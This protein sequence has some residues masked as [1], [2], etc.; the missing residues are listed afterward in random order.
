MALNRKCNHHHHHQR[1]KVE[2]IATIY[3]ERTSMKKID[4]KPETHVG[5]LNEDF[6]K[7]DFYDIPSSYNRYNAAVLFATYLTFNNIG[8]AGTSRSNDLISPQ[9]FDDSIY[10]FIDNSNI[11]AGFNL[12]LETANQRNVKR[13]CL[14]ASKPL[15]KPLTQA[16]QAGYEC[17]VLQQTQA[18]ST[19]VLASGNGNDAEYNE[20]G[21]YKSTPSFPMENLPQYMNEI[22][23]G[24]PFA[25]LVLMH[26]S[27][28]LK[29][30]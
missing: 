12:N 6:K 8:F 23:K 9:K 27:A 18:P 22:G 15:F 21:F 25:L 14:A 29:E 20:G 13:K 7:F 5:K 30:A 19:L 11:L 1:R 26:L 24:L 17:S 3:E 4:K 10:V 16:E 28:K 2:S